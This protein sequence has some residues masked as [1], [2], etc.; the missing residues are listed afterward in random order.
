MYNTAICQLAFN[1]KFKLSI[2]IFSRC[3]AQAKSCYYL[4]LILEEANST[5]TPTMNET[6]AAWNTMNCSVALGCSYPDTYK[7]GTLSPSYVDPRICS[8]SSSSSRQGG[9]TTRASTTIIMQ[10]L[11]SLG[12]MDKYRAQSKV[13]FVSSGKVRQYIDLD[14]ITNHFVRARSVPSDIAVPI[15]FDSITILYHPRTF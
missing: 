6:Q 3:A 5:S 11:K 9:P 7:V 15:A 4:L 10:L 2:S 8:S 13:Y 1:D 12:P 14:R